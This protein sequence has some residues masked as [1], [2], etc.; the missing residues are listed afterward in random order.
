MGRRIGFVV[1]VLATM[2]LTVADAQGQPAKKT[3]KISVKTGY[4]AGNPP[5]AQPGGEF[6]VSSTVAGDEYQ[7]LVDYGTFGPGGTFVVWN[8]VAEITVGINAQIGQTIY[9]WGPTAATNLNNP[10]Q[11]LLVRAR[12][13]WRPT[14]NA[15]WTTIAESITI[16]P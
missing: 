13:Q 9:T 1:A 3:G 4:Q 2:L 12:L 5:T 16:C 6:T 7:V 15:A 14:I 10:P 8:G 11:G